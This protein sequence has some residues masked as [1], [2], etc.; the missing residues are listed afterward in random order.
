MGCDIHGFARRRRFDKT[1]HNIAR[2]PHDRNYTLFALL[3]NVRNYDGVR[4]FIDTET[5]DGDVGVPDDLVSLVNGSGDDDDAAYDDPNYYFTDLGDHSF[6]TVDNP[7][8]LLEWDGWDQIVDRTRWVERAEYE[9]FKR[10]GGEPQ[11]YCGGV[12]GRDVVHAKQA[13]VEAGTAPENWNYV[14]YTWPVKVREECQTFLHWLQWIADEYCWLDRDG[15]PF[16]TVQIVI[17][18]DS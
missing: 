12:A 11:S 16:H 14:E 5:R 8:A 4:P 2:V 6:I 7:R 17:G 15:T 10:D 9:R 13:D 1:W 3:A 18:F